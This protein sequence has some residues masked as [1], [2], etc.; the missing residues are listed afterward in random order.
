MGG[1]GG[2][3]RRHAAYLL[4]GTSSGQLL[5]N[6]SQSKQRFCSSRSKRKAP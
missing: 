6:F 4:I 5:G 2:R 1:E 3:A